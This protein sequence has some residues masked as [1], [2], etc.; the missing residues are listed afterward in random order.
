MSV[1]LSNFDV[2]A[3]L[4]EELPETCVRPRECRLALYRWCR[5]CTSRTRGRGGAGCGV[6]ARAAAARV[7]VEEPV[8][9]EPEKWEGHN[10]DP[11]GLNGVEGEEECG[12]QGCPCNS[13]RQQQRAPPCRGMGADAVQ[14]AWY[15]WGIEGSTSPRK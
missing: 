13:D 14:M 9:P 15:R 1:C 4:F 10:G 5:G 11:P 7:P 12:V 6:G 8:A 3:V 2:E